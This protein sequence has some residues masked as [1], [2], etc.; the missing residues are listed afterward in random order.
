MLGFGNGKYVIGDCRASGL[1]LCQ[2]NP[3]DDSS[4]SQIRSLANIRKRKGER[5]PTYLEP[6]ETGNHSD[7]FD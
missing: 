1:L 3:K 5:I 4:G 2:D 6:S 7:F